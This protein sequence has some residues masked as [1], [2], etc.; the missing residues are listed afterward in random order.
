[1]QI[2][3]TGFA[4]ECLKEISQYY[5]EV[6]GA[7]ISRKIRSHIFHATRHLSKHPESGQEEPFLMKQDHVY[8][9]IV[10][11]RYKIIYTIVS[12]KI[13]ITDVFDTRQNPIMMNKPGR[14]R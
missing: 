1:M 2:I 8:R 9:Y 11:D 3:W 4:I 10:A 6:A 12:D 14:K 5:K 7:K 13:L